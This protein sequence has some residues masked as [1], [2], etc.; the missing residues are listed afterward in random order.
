MEKYSED[1]TKLWKEQ[2]EKDIIETASASQSLKRQ[3]MEDKLLKLRELYSDVKE[4][5]AQV[6]ERINIPIQMQ[7]WYYSKMIDVLDEMR[8]DSDTSNDYWEMVELYKDIFCTF[9]YDSWSETIYQISVSGENY[10]LD[11]GNP[12]WT[13]LTDEL[14]EN[15]ERIDRC[16]AEQIE[17]N[18]ADEFYSVISRDIADAEYELYSSRTRSLTIVVHDK[19]LIFHGED[20]GKG[21]DKICGSDLYE[22]VYKLDET[23]TFKLFYA[24][25]KQYVLWHPVEKVLVQEF[26]GEEGS[27]RFS[28]YCKAANV[29]YY[30]WAF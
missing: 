16:L 20:S 9:Y 7:A 28:E 11:S 22:F 27:S 6:W 23:Q 25:R 1:R 21:C 10:Y 2:K 19:K 8:K 3:V 15:I 4:I 12:E 26:G 14:P 24:L 5:G 29:K 18:W 30:F 13:G 17:D